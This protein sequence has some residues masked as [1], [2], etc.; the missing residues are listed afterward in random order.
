MDNEGNQYLDN[1]Y[2]MANGLGKDEPALLI[3][4]IGFDLAT[5]QRTAM[6]VIRNWPD[7][8]EISTPKPKKKRRRAPRVKKVQLRT[9]MWSFVVFLLLYLTGAFI[10]WEI[11]IFHWG[12]ITPVDVRLILML[13]GLIGF[14][15]GHSIAT[16]DR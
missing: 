3:S 7:S 12:S 2:E 4:S 10:A 6:D 11:N 9:L 14:M 13:F 16:T 15:V 1:L 5:G 8:N